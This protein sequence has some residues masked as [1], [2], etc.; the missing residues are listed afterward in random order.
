[1][2][3]KGYMN[4]K[5]KNRT[6]IIRKTVL[7]TL[8]MMTA[9]VGISGISVSAAENIRKIDDGSGIATPSSVVEETALVMDSSAYVFSNS[10][11]GM[12]RI[13]FAE[14]KSYYL[15][16]A[17]DS[18]TKITYA[19]IKYGTKLYLVA[20]D[21]SEDNVEY[22]GSYTDTT[23]DMLESKNYNS[24]IRKVKMSLKYGK[25]IELTHFTFN[26]DYSVKLS[27]YYNGTYYTDD[28]AATGIFERNG[29]CDYFVGGKTVTADGWYK[30]GS[31]SPT[32]ELV[33]T[34]I[35]GSI[36]SA[37]V[38]YVHL[39]EGHVQTAYHGEKCYSYTGT[40]KTAVKSRKVLIN[41]IY[42]AYDSKG[43]ALS[44][45]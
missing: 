1:M 29:Y 6:Y 9:F 24:S 12:F 7:R 15:G 3:H 35:S 4:L 43:N 41:N 40:K 16:S 32:G 39:F 14:G 31:A 27:G 5:N 37:T 34:D 23:F 19:L 33:D 44:V 36:G 38:K 2:L 20:A 11:D 18:D 28:K 26:K 21:D 8:L 45:L 10:T 30:Y 13:S 22:N 17:E 25:N 42:V